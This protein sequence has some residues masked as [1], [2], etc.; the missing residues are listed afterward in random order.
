MLKGTRAP[1]TQ[2]RK[3]EVVDGVGHLHIARRRTQ[4]RRFADGWDSVSE[5]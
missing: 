5:L 2:I 1:G 4:R 3:A